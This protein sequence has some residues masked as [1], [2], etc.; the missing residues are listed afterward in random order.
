MSKGQHSDLLSD[1]GPWYSTR[2]KDYLSPSIT[3]DTEESPTLWQGRPGKPERQPGRHRRKGP[4]SRRVSPRLV[5]AAVFTALLAAPALWMADWIATHNGNE[6]SVEL[7][8]HNAYVPM[9]LYSNGGR[10]PICVY[11]QNSNKGWKAW[12]S[13]K[14]C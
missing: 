12:A 10:E 6:T 3:Q 2:S 5:T 4:P 7:V 9:T 14:A 1:R 13:T 11:I 8:D